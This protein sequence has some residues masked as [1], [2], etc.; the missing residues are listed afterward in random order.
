MWRSCRSC[1]ASPE[2]L[3]AGVNPEHVTASGSLPPG[4]PPVEVGGEL[5]WGGGLLIQHAVAMYG[6]LLSARQSL[7]LS[8]RRISSARSIISEVP[9]ENGLNPQQKYGSRSA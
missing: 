7:D 1:C 5:Y 2:R 6:R 9:D 3:E 4:F 8:G